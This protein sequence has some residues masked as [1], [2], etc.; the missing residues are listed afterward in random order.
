M[1]VTTR[2]EKKIVIELSLSE[3]LWLL[4]CVKKD[5]TKPK[6]P[7]QEHHRLPFFNQLDKEVRAL[8]GDP[9]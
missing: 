1:N 9:K 6:Y 2:T 8:K 7:N 4:G 3:A 5:D